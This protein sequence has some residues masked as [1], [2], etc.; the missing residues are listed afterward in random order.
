MYF[1]KLN[2]ERTR[3]TDVWKYGVRTSAGPLFWY[4]NKLESAASG[5]GAEVAIKA[6]WSGCKVSRL[7]QLTTFLSEGYAGVITGRDALPPRFDWSR[8]TSFHFLT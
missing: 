3:V 6:L 4:G 8:W 2:A 1:V 5:G 7:N